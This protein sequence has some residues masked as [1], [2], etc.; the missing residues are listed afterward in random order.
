MFDFI[1]GRGKS[2]DELEPIRR[3]LMR[4]LNLSRRI[5]LGLAPGAL[6]AILALTPASA[7][8]NFNVKN[9]GATGNGVTNDT[10]ALQSCFAAAN[11]VQGSNIVFPPGNYLYEGNLIVSGTGVSVVGEHATLISGSTSAVLV[12]N[13][14]RESVQGL[15]FSTQVDSEFALEFEQ[16]TSFLAQNNTFNNGFDTCVFVVQA[17]NGQLLSNRFS[18]N[19]GAGAFAVEDSSK[20]LIES[21]VGGGNF[22]QDFLNVADSN[23]ISV[24]SNRFTD[25]A[26]IGFATDCDTISYQHNVFS[27]LQSGIT[28]T[29]VNNL[30]ISGNELSASS[31]TAAVALVLSGGQNTLIASN[32]MQIGQIGVQTGGTGNLQVIGNTMSNFQTETFLLTGG[33]TVIAKGNTITRGGIA[34]FTGGNSNLT[35]AGNQIAQCQ[36]QAIQSEDDAGTLTISNNT[37]RACGLSPNS[38]PA[39][40]FVDS[41]GATSIPIT[42]NSYTGNTANLQFFIRCIQPE[43]PAQV[44]G[45]STNT[46]LPTVVG[47]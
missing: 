11:A 42:H 4:K 30:T 7:A 24:V 26:V 18:F 39:V 25:L 10:S 38:P 8:Q 46:G 20:I 43:P 6:F 29:D 40:I 44:S 2:K 5:L 21:N 19:T 23:N 41:P 14:T 37:T 31:T 32:T 27:Y 1:S 3:E 16:A 9:F 34:I 36:Q 35:V 17:S 28:F 45:N 33:S 47:P 13:G 22:E 15:T 12:C